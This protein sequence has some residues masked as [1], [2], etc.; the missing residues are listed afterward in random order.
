MFL[1]EP[2]SGLDPIGAGDFDELIRTLQQ[3]LGI[4]VYM[5]T[6]DLDSLHA[7]CD[8][9][10]VLSDGKVIV[11]G[12][13]DAMLACDHPWVKEYFRGKRSRAAGMAHPPVEQGVTWV[14]THDLDATCAFY[15]D[16][17]GLED[18]VFV[19]EGDRCWFVEVGQIRLMES[20]GNYTRVHFGSE[21]PLLF[22]S[23]NAMEERLDPAVFFRANRQQIVNLRWIDK[24]EPW[25]SGGLALDLKGGGRVEPTVKPGDRVLYARRPD[26]EFMEGPELFTFVF[27]EQG[28][29]GVLEAA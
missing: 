22:R 13:M 20:E 15:R 25:F 23:L 5:V 3:T 14:Y 4:T 27:E 10:A 16:R 17:L 26:C 8:R 1:D 29:L 6:H 19:R 7:I 11:E 18:K 24:I 28:I 9:I 2:T 12:P 21:N